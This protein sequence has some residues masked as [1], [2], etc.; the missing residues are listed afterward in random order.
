MKKPSKKIRNA[1]NFIEEQD[2]MSQFHKWNSVFL[3]LVDE[4]G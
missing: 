3:N 2:A 1:F 4:N